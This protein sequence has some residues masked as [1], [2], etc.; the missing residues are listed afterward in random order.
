MEGKCKNCVFWRNDFYWD[1]EGRDEL[2]ETTDVGRCDVIQ[3]GG[4]KVKA[5]KAVESKADKNAA[6]VFDGE[7]Y[8]GGLIT[9]ED[10]S[11]SL[12]QQ[13]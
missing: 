2:K 4:D 3:H 9:G 12:F 13:K 1:G 7:D 11:C 8:Q 5:I 10:F 6:V